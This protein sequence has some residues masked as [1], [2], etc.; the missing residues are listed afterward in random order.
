MEKPR[1]KEQNN[2][3]RRKTIK[4]RTTGEKEKI[5]TEGMIK[6]ITEGREGNR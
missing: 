1:R 3:R 5:K 4:G 6:G 2:R